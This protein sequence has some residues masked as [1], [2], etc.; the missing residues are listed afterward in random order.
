MSLLPT[1]GRIWGRH[2]R[3]TPE[4]VVMNTFDQPGFLHNPKEINADLQHEMTSSEIFKIAHA[5]G[6]V[7]GKLNIIS[8]A[9]SL[10]SLKPEKDTGFR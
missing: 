1:P 10:E 7:K 5:H 3:Q 8:S 9:T 2:E 6:H 4:R